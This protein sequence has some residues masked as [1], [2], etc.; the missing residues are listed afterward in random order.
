MPLNT[1]WWAIWISFVKHPGTSCLFYKLVCLPFHL[2]VAVLYVSWMS[3]FRYIYVCM[4]PCA[5]VCVLCACVYIWYKLSQS[6][7]GRTPTSL[8]PHPESQTVTIFPRYS[9]ILPFS[10]LVFLSQSRLSSVH[11]VL[12]PLDISVFSPSRAL[13][14]YRGCR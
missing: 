10:K 8:S 11:G 6:V 1:C 7:T 5:C 13:Q 2:F 3:P 9:F 14:S 4:W 12:S